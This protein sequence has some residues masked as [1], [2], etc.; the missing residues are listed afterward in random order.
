MRYIAKKIEEDIYEV[1]H[2]NFMETEDGNKVEVVMGKTRPEKSK[3][4]KAI[5]DLKV[6]RPLRI[7]KMDKDIEELE[8]QLEAINNSN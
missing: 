2:L 6:E 7:E 3:L 8:S 5:E 1:T 4:E